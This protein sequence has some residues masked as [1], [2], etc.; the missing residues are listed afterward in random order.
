[1]T[2]LSMRWPAVPHSDSDQEIV[3]LP[4]ERPEVRPHDDPS[5][6]VCGL[7]RLLTTTEDEAS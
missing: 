1:M 5:G 6:H 7:I 4:T 2:R 3:E